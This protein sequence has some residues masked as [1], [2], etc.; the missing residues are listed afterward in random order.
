VAVTTR[1]LLARGWWVLVGVKKLSRE[2]SPPT[3]CFSFIKTLNNQ[4]LW[5][6]VTLTINT[7]TLTVPNTPILVSVHAKEC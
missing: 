1:L 6:R 4:K 5:L 3:R 7:R 2:L